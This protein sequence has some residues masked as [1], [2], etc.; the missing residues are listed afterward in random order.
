MP[1]VVVLIVVLTAWGVGAAVGS[2]SSYLVGAVV[3]VTATLVIVGVYG[4]I[5]ARRNSRRD[6]WDVAPS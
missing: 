4:A 5:V 3:G 1:F 2:A 6:D